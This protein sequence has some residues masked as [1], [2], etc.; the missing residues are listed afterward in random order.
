V[1]VSDGDT[2]T[3][4]DQSNQQH[5]IRLNGI[6]APELNQD[7]GQAAKRNLS[8]LV[9]DQEVIVNWDSRDRYGRIVGKVMAGPIDVNCEQIRAGYAWYFRKYAGD[10]ATPDRPL[11]EQIEQEA[12]AAG[13]GLWRQPNPIPPWEWRVLPQDESVPTTAEPAAPPLSGQIIGNRNSRIY[14]RP[15]CP[16]YQKVFEKNR[17]YFSTTEEAERKGFRPAGNCPKL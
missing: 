15:D 4:L 12:R 9:F 7:F 17:V 1:G 11:Y 13:R 2:L 10:V 5:K 3:V 16:D 14:H 6:D 8:S